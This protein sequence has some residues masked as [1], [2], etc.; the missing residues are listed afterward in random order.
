[1]EAIYMDK[2]Q[3]DQNFFSEVKEKIEKNPKDIVLL[4]II[5]AIKNEIKMMTENKEELT[6]EKFNISCK[7]LIKQIKHH[8]LWQRKITIY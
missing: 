5:D 3:Y 2:D 6:I 1:M 4:R 7:R 8:I